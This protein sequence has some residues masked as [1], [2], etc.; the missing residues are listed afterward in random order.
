MLEIGTHRGLIPVE[1]RTTFIFRISC[2]R[3]RYPKLSTVIKINPDP[4]DEDLSSVKEA[5]V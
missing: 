5:V 3:E 2:D 1:C 4:R